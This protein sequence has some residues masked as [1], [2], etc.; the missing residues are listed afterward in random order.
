VIGTGAAAP[1]SAVGEG[2]DTLIDLVPDW[3]WMALVLVSSAFVV[4]AVS[5]SV[6]VGGVLDEP[7]VNPIAGSELVAATGNLMQR[8]KHT[9]KAGRLLQTQ[10]HRDLCREFRIDVAAPL[11]ELDSVVA[12]RSSMTA[13]DVE[14]T[15]RHTISNDD[16]LLELS[17][18]IDRIRKEVLT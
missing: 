3:A 14:L 9:S 4:F 13:G 10:L 5:R 8:A 6:R 18:Q 17:G 11:V 2:D 15:L 1:V 7:L 12:A 16:Q